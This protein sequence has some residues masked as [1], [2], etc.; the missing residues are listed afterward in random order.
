[1]DTMG[2]L[3]APRQLGY[4]TALGCE[5]AVHATSFYLSNLK[6]GQVIFKLD[7]ENAFNCI[8]LDKMLQAVQSGTGACPLCLLLQ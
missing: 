2:L 3:L 6:P 4:S 1:M 5:A 8:C 7:F